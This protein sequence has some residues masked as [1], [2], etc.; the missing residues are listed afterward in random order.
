MGSEHWRKAGAAPEL[1][2]LTMDNQPS[3]IELKALVKQ[4]LD[5]CV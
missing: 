2:S 4:A 3:I 1:A 5:L